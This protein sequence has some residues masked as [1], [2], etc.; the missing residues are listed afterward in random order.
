MAASS[1]PDDAQITESTPALH[2]LVLAYLSLHTR[3]NFL[4]GDRQVVSSSKFRHQ[5]NQLEQVLE[6]KE[7]SASGHRHE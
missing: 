2:R 6:A 7:T 1:V 3:R 5:V 4:Y